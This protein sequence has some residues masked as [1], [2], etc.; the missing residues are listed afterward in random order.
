MDESSDV[1]QCA[2]CCLDDVEDDGE[3]KFGLLPPDGSVRVFVYLKQDVD[4]TREATSGVRIIT[5]LSKY[6]MSVSRNG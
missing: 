5:V 1:T 3:M 4:E 6:N 2:G